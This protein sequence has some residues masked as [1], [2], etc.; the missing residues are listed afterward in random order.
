MEY[1]HKCV[2]VHLAEPYNWEADYYFGSVSAVYDVLSKDILGIAVTSLRNVLTK[3]N[4]NFSNKKCSIK[5]RP[6]MRKEQRN[7][8]DGY[9]SKRGKAEAEEEQKR[10]RI[11]WGK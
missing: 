2:H 9:F 3:S 6:Y 8:G 5:I 7:R 10:S 11:V 1:R 4:P